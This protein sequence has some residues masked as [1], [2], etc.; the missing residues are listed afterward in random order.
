MRVGGEW[1]VGAAGGGGVRVGGGAVTQ[2]ELWAQWPVS[3][4][5]RLRAGWASSAPCAAAASPRPYAPVPQLRLRDAPA[6]K[7]V[8]LRPGKERSL[9]SA[10]PGSSRAPSP[11]RRRCGRDRAG[12][13]GRRPVPGLGGL[14]PQSQIRLRAWSFDE[15]SASTRPSSSAASP[16]RG[17][18]RAAADRATRAPG[19][20]R[21]RRPARPDRGPLR[22]HPGGAVHQRRRRALEGRDRRRA[23]GRHRPTRLYERSDAQA[24]EWEGPCRPAGCAAR[25]TRR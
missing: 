4:R 20:R 25:A 8:T 5:L 1:L 6:M 3:E 11:G 21:G 23:A 17:D 19:P 7:T 18:A 13:V 24:R 14:Q 10:T 15:A 2:A 12:G 16:A 22:R 9:S